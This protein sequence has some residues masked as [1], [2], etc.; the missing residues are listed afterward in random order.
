VDSIHP[1]AQRQQSGNEQCQ[2]CDS[3]FYLASPEFPHS[4][5]HNIH[6]TTLGRNGI[7]DQSKEHGT[8]FH[9]TFVR[10]QRANAPILTGVD[11]PLNMYPADASPGVADRC[12]ANGRF[13]G[14]P[15]IAATPTSC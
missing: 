1:N 7:G 15:T 10:W 14:I 11:W 5:T 8:L 13:P 2:L 6:R 3:E 9:S 12:A 4:V